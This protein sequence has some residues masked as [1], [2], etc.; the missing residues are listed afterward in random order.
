MLEL[1]LSF[2]TERGTLRFEVT[3]EVRERPTAPSTGDEDGCEVKVVLRAE[4]GF[5]VGAAERFG[6]RVKESSVVDEF[7]LGLSLFVSDAP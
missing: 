2:D 7:A 1:E 6:D 3:E 4:E 5:D